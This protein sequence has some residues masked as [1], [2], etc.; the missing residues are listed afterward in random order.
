MT[1]PDRDIPAAALPP[2]RFARET[3]R[4]VLADIEAKGD[5]PWHV[6]A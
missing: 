4:L 5:R 2:A 6:A 1:V 3:A